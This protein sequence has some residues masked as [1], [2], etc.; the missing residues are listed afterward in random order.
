MHTVGLYRTAA[1]GGH[2]FA[3]SLCQGR[4]TR[5]DANLRVGV[6][7]GDDDP[8]VGSL[9]AA[10]CHAGQLLELFPMFSDEFAGEANKRSSSRGICGFC[11]DGG[12]N[13]NF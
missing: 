7:Q 1:N 13:S 2:P 8:A 5:N 12:A 10:F 4:I 6:R 3:D 11:H 9:R